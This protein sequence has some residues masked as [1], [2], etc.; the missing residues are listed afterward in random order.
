MARKA[1]KSKV[2]KFSKA[3][4]SKIASVLH[5]IANES[6][7]IIFVEMIR[8]GE[9]TVTSLAEAAGLSQSGA[10]QH[11]GKMRDAGLVSFRRD[12]QTLWYRV[13]DARVQDLIEVL[14]RLFCRHGA[15]PSRH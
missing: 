9:A 6:R 3:E 13:V 5:V 2:P 7:L 15:H 12:S 8:S 1:A 11:L 14:N 4:V 10:S